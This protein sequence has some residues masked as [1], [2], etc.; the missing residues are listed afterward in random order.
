MRVDGDRPD[1]ELGRGAQDAYRDFAAIR[2]EEPLER[3]RLGHC[4]SLKRKASSA[5]GTLTIIVGLSSFCLLPALS[6]TDP[7]SNCMCIQAMP[8]TMSRASVIGATMSQPSTA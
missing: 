3:R 5:C 7:T 2:H 1:I 6:L 8:P 4:Q